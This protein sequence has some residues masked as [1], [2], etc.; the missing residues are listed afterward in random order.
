MDKFWLR[1]GQ[2]SFLLLLTVLFIGCIGVQGQS[3]DSLT[4]LLAQEDDAH[5][6]AVIHRK[7]AESYFNQHKFKLAEE[8]LLLAGKLCADDTATYFY[9]RHLL[10]LSGVY[11]QQELYNKSLAYAMR[12]LMLADIHSRMDITGMANLNTSIALKGLSKNEDAK[13]F[14]LEALKVFREQNDS[15]LIAYA[16]NTLGMILKNLDAY[17]AASEYYRQSLEFRR[18]LGKP[19][20]VIVVLGNMA[21]LEKIRG[22]YDSAHRIYNEAGRLARQSGSPLYLAKNYYN[23]ADLMISQADTSTAIPYLDSCLVIAEENGFIPLASQSSKWLA[24][25]H[26][27]TKNYKVAYRYNKRFD[28]Y[29]DSI[30]ALDDVMDFNEPRLLLENQKKQS[31]IDNLELQQARNIKIFLI[32]VIILLFVI[33]ILV[34]VRSVRIKKA[35]DLLDISEKKFRALAEN[36]VEVLWSSDLDLNLTYISPSTENLLGYNRGDEKMKI[37]MRE[38]FGEES[39][40]LLKAEVDQKIKAYKKG[41]QGTFIRLELRGKHVNGEHVWVEITAD[42]I[43]DDHG[44]RIGLQGIARNITQRKTAEIEKNKVLEDLS[45]QDKTLKQQNEQLFI[46][47]QEAEKTAQQYFDLFENGPVGYLIITS[48]GNVA[49]LNSTAA[50]MLGVEKSAAAGKPFETFLLHG[51]NVDFASCLAKTIQ[52]SE[53]VNR[54]FNFNNSAV[55]ILFVP[56]EADGRVRCRIAMTNITAE[57]EAREKLSVALHSM[58]TVF[59]AIPGGVL[60]V[61]REFRIVNL[62]KRLQQIH[63][64]ADPVEIVGKKFHQVFKCAKEPGES[65]QWNE[66][67]QT[68][69]TRVRHSSATDP[70][71]KSGN[72]RIYS[73]PMLD[74]NGNIIGVVE[75]AMDISDLKKAESALAESE[76]KFKDLFNDIPDAVFITGIGDKSGEILDVNAAAVKQTGYTRAELLHMN[77]LRDISIVKTGVELTREREE[78]LK[79]DDKIELTERKRCK[80]GSLIWTEV[81][82]QKIVIDGEVLAMSVSRDI[83]ER[84]KIQE[85]LKNSESRVS[86]LLDALPDLL[87]ILNKDGVFLEYYASSLDQLIALP[88]TFLN[89]KVEDAL[90]DYLARLTRENIGRAFETGRMQLYNYHFDTPNERRYF[91]ARMVKASDSTVLTVVRDIT[92]AKKV[93]EYHRHNEEKYKTIFLN[94]P[95]GLFNFDPRGII[96]DCNDHFVKIMG[97]SREELIGFNMLEMPENNKLQAVI[98]QVV[99]AGSSSFEGEY[100]SVT[101]NKTTPIRAFFKI[102]KDD[103]GEFVDGIGIVEDVS[104]QR[105]Y[106]EKLLLA[107]QQAEQSDKLKSSFMA[108]MSHELRT[109]LNTVIGFADMIEESMPIDQVLEFAH[110]ISKSGKHLLSIIEDILDISL[111]DS[112]EVKLVVSRFMVNELRDGLNN[113]AQ[114]QR[115]DMGKEDIHIATYVSESLAGEKFTGD[116]RK[117]NKVFGHLIKNALK[118]TK[119]GEIEI[120]IDGDSKTTSPDHVLLYVKDTGI[121]IPKDKHNIIFEIFRQADDSSTREFEGTGLG[122]SISKKLIDMMGGR[123]WL[124]SEPGSG[125]VFYFELPLKAGAA[126]TIE[127]FNKYLKPKVKTMK[128]VT[129]LVAEDDDTNFHLFKLLLTRR[130]IEVIRA[131]DG[132]E[133]VNKI[134]DNPDVKL[135]LMDINMPV[136]NGYEATKA[137]KEMRK[138]LPVIAVTAYAMVGDKE[139]AEDAGCDDYITKPINNQVFY[140]TITRYV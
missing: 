76:R 137:I 136:L 42:F 84:V 56:D 86:S 121:G 107:K 57:V 112:G 98:R 113:F 18:K 33:I 90:P 105:E 48:E 102:I 50:K 101:A 120:G 45:R 131:R 104:A 35:K 17:D 15:I 114:Q 21:I 63:N 74:D 108:T 73:S 9:N 128:G 134:K 23:L 68:G 2:L 44:Q 88:E 130:Q 87:F 10:S 82:V 93:E 129:V 30:V 66:V 96:I 25:L 69:K 71:Y 111:I 27:E 31:R 122:L 16:S 41:A 34:F 75:A 83:S 38:V 59:D 78:N 132:E 72:Y 47:R 62:N 140:E 118:F 54:E 37:S 52:N 14:A 26:F 39:Y 106:E 29:R 70:V 95:L 22:N 65:C 139:R 127:N 100:T 89:K 64:L 13:K 28:G 11:I 126:R 115:Y 12:A 49:E 7:V 79:R 117:I 138:E 6:K 135:V 119:S 53:V 133:S 124:K 58:Q 36:S 125:S 97:S 51:Q 40:R 8:H 60:V 5:E 110:V 4:S 92:H 55:R 85:E 116:I 20:D 123:I 109:P 32:V 19:N 46:T 91:D 103:K 3:I 80:D 94:T 67:L 99:E 61:N 24:D 43:Y 81:V 77:V 1:L